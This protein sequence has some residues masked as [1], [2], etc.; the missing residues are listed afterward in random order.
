MTSIITPSLVPV[1]NNAKL[2]TVNT[3]TGKFAFMSALGT[4]PT[5]GWSGVVLSPVY[6]ATPPADGIW[7]VDFV[8]DPPSGQVLPIEL[9]VAATLLEP[10]PDWL[11]GI[12]IRASENEI[13]ETGLFVST[14]AENESDYAKTVHN[15]QLE[16][17]SSNAIVS[18]EIAVYDDSHQP[19]GFCGGFPPSIKMKKLRHRLVLTI[20]GPDEAKIRR[21]INEAIAAGLLAA[22]VAVFITGG[23]ALSAAIAAL[24]SYLISCLGASFDMRVDRKSHWIEWCT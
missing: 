14:M 11:K 3:P 21:C 8:A 22:I 6:Y 17:Y 16:E 23:A 1:V 4:V 19:I 7:D 15:K 9:P 20:V 13:V 12:R 10:S 5:S 24:K 18:K 2:A